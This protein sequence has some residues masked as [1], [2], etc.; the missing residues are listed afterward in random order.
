MKEW[1]FM[2]NYTAARGEQSLAAIVSQSA[3]LPNAL[4][5]LKIALN[6]RLA[7]PRVAAAASGE[8]NRSEETC[9]SKTAVCCFEWA[10]C[11]RT[12][13]KC[14]FYGFDTD[15]SSSPTEWEKKLIKILRQKEKNCQMGFWVFWK[16]IKTNN[17]SSSSCSIINP[18]DPLVDSKFCVIN[19]RIR[20]RR[21]T[22][23][24]ARFVRRRKSRRRQTKSSSIRQL[25]LLLD[26]D[27]FFRRLQHRINDSLVQP[28][29][30]R[31]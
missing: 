7:R 23:N 18:L 27:D 4:L 20:R 30:E 12:A 9:K 26:L 2:I 13:L 16:N 21:R 14:F 10:A 24:D 29:N 19:S 22:L 8:L 31:L 5:A 28:L 6:E 15:F 3:K 17:F 25:S 1:N 11:S